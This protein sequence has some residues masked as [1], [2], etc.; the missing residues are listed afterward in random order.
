MQ[1][2]DQ[3]I[4]YLI[5]HRRCPGCGSAY[6]LENVHVLNQPERW[7]WDLAAVCHDCHAL[8]VVS[9]VLRPDGADRAER[10]A[11]R[12]RS[13][14]ELTAAERAYFGELAPVDENDVLDLAEFLV[15]FDGDFRGLFSRGP[16]GA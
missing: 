12:R 10:L 3:V 11:A 15:A 2:V 7:T 9:A 13:V 14:S 16:D 5:A 1:R 4:Q 6:R 8:T